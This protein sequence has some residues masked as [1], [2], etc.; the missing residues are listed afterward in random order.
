MF[1]G[2]CSF[3]V[4]QHSR[5]PARRSRSDSDVP[6]K[7]EKRPEPERPQR[8]RTEPPPE[9]VQE[10]HDA[11]LKAWEKIPYSKFRELFDEMDVDEDGWVRSYDT[12]L[13]NK[14]SSNMRM[15]N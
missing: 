3:R 13:T 15:T 8:S 9:E 7:E 2:R 1:G 5:W 14:M 10:L 11:A 12:L 6:P 4:G